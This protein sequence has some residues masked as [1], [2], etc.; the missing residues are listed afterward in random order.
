MIGGGFSHYG[1]LRSE[2]GTSLAGWPALLSK[3]SNF[4]V[5]SSAVIVVRGNFSH[6]PVRK[7]PLFEITGFIRAFSLFQLPT[8]HGDL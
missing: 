5:L 2:L 7:W 1:K 3:H 6:F 8:G 4:W